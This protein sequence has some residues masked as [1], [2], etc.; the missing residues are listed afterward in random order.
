[1]RVKAGDRI[2]GDVGTCELD[3]FWGLLA[4]GVF[5]PVRRRYKRLVCPNGSWEKTSW[6]V[7]D[8]DRRISCGKQTTSLQMEVS[9][10]R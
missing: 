1:M 5:G 4:V 3:L 8:P 9:E 2:A 6:G 7:D 10:S